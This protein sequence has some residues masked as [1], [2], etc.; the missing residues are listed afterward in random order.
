MCLLGKNAAMN[1]GSPQPADR[2][3]EE[4]DEESA[5]SFPASD[6][7]AAPPGEEHGDDD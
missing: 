7:P 3:G 6:P 2:D 1:S 4:V 5:A